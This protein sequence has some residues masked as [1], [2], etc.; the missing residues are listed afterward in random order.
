MAQRGVY[1]DEVGLHFKGSK[2]A[3]ND[4]FHPRPRRRRLQQAIATENPCN[5]KS[6]IG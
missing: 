1:H 5:H 4:V 2:E 3:V 6:V